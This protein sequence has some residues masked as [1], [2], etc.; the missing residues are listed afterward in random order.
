L[1]LPLEEL[2]KEDGMLFLLTPRAGSSR[3]IESV[4]VSRIPAAPP[5]PGEQYRFHFDM[6][7]CI[8]CRCCEVA[9]SEQNNN[10]ADI[11]WR[12][13][14]E[15]EGGSYPF[16]Q[17][18]YLSMGCN[19]CLEPACL[20]GCPVDAY[21]KDALTGLV[22]HSSDACIGCHYCTW[23]CAYGVPQYNQERGVVGKCDMC[24]GRLNEGREPACVNACPEGAIRV[25]TVNIA[26]WLRDY[27]E[28]ANAPGL[29]PA[30]HTVS[31]TR[32]TLPAQ[33]PAEF[34][35][36]DSHRV[37]PQ[38][39]HW[40]LVVMTVLTQLSVGAFAGLWLLGAFGLPLTSQFAALA[41]LAVGLLSLGASTFHL[42][43][44]AYAY[45]ALKMWRRSWLSREVLLFTGFAFTAGAYAAVLFADADYGG[46][47]GAIP[48]LLGA[49]G[50]GASAFIYMVPARPAW[51]SKYTLAE[52]FSTA[53]LL[54]P[55]FLSAFGAPLAPFA[56]AGGAAQLLTQALRLLWLV[57]SDEFELRASARLLSTDLRR[58]LLARFLLLGLGGV[59]LPLLGHFALALP[60][61]LAGEI[62]GR[63]L[64]FVGTV[65]KNMAAAFSAG[66][67]RAA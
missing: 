15:I 23:N 3:T 4:P 16:T 49:A 62:F 32:I 29:P 11:R 54:G 65:P 67:R 31:T 10:P 21:N 24:Y 56:I 51:A 28:Q 34:Q 18:L 6:T 47:F 39:P 46:F 44:P 43:R 55:L 66:G 26:E 40:P 58:V 59:L 5:G 41:A 53:L 35:N 48:A 20:T 12:R 63:C 61:A 19:H 7:K 17:R 25:E 50:I 38:D 27:P 36:A 8:G 42:G 57:S 30:E 13:V 33:V 14:G 52:F 45:R 64:F 37:R 22:L 9:C 2:A 60:V 1:S